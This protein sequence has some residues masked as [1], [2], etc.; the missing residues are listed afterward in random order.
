[1]GIRFL[2]I[3]VALI[4]L[5]YLAAW[6]RKANPAQRK[7][8]LRNIAMYGGA[9]ALL[10]LVATGRAHWIF[11]I[12]AAATPWIQR[13]MMAMRAWNSFKAFG[14]PAKG[15]QSNV[16][17]TW[18]SMSLDHDSGSID[19]EILAGAFK[20]S[21]MSDL[22][23]DQLLELIQECEKADPQS[24]PLIEAFLDQTQGPEWRGDEEATEARAEAV[25]GPMTRP[26]ALAILGIEETASASD[27]RTAHRS[28]M[29][30]VHPDRG[31]SAFLATRINQARDL[32][33]ENKN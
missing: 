29:Q 17:T 26:E 11:A 10:I 16:G 12:L 23:L 25:S 24:V 2:L 30:K 28:L 32:L 6:L 22:N 4:G 15:R 5:M 19:G 3:A 21:M 27:I 13:G 1:M 33:L 18:L 8:M 20:G 31:G 9:L 7:I 14:G